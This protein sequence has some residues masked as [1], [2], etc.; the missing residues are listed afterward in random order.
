MADLTGFTSSLSC[1]FIF[2]II[3]Y[4]KDAG[5]LMISVLSAVAETERENIRTQTM[6]GREQNKY[7][8]RNGFV[9]KLRQNNTIPGFSGNFVQDRLDNLYDKIEDIDDRLQD[10]NEKIRM[11]YENQI[12]S[13]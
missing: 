3:S 5:K 7:L 13:K 2:L 10:V 11:A 8:N 1:F 6:A 12:I 4:K 9:K